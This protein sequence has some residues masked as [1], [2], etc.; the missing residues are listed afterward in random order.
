MLIDKLVYVP[1]YIT[2]PDAAFGYILGIAIL[3]ILAITLIGLVDNF[4]NR[5]KF[6]K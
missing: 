2:I 1:K 6:N 5:N 3:A 4:Y